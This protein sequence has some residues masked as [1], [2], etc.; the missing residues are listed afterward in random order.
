MF[1]AEWY[2]DFIALLTFGGDLVGACHFGAIGE[3]MAPYSAEV[4]GNYAVATRERAKSETDD[5]QR[6]RRLENS[7]RRFRRAAALRPDVPRYLAEAT[8]L[9]RLLTSLQGNPSRT[10]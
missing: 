3:G 9:E 6:I 1:A 4:I 5:V 8:A 7:A 2:R 10:L